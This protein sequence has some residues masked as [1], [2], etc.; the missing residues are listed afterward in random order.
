MRASELESERRSSPVPQ[1]VMGSALVVPKIYLDRLRGA[2]AGH[3]IDLGK[4]NE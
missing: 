1:V 2:V 4:G 3:Y